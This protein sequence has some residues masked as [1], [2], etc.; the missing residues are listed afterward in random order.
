M[1]VLVFFIMILSMRET[2][3]AGPIFMNSK[4]PLQILSKTL[5]Y[6]PHEEKAIFEGNVEVTQEKNKLNCDVIIVTFEKN[7]QFTNLKDKNTEGQSTV[8]SN[9]RK[10]V[11]RIYAKGNVVMY[12]NANKEKIEAGN[13]EYDPKSSKIIF[14]DNVIITKGEDN[15]QATKIVGSKLE[16]S[17]TTGE[18]MMLSGS[19]ERVKGRFISE[20]E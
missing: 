8:F 3:A 12:N 17:T 11:Q 1:K 5:R 10:K 18:S 16:Y 9:D 14:L 20:E 7:E 4:K 15:T 6:I 13:A 19:N 2:Y